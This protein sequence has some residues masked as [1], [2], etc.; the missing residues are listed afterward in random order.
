MQA[1]KSEV[2]LHQTY[3]SMLFLL[4]QHDVIQQQGVKSTEAVLSDSKMRHIWGFLF[5][6]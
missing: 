6:Q 3:L 1:K 4:K 2:Y 5:Q